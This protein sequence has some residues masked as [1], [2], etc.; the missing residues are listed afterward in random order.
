MALLRSDAPILPLIHA[1]GDPVSEVRTQA[2]AA[3]RE[4]SAPVVLPALLPMLQD[5]DEEVRGAAALAAGDLGAPES[6]LVLLEILRHGSRHHR[7]QAAVCLRNL[8][9]AAVVPALMEALGDP[10]PS[11]QREAAVSL[12]TL[13]DPQAAPVLIDALGATNIMDEER[14][15]L[16]ENLVKALGDLEDPR[17]APALVRALD[18]Y[19]KHVRAAAV[20]SLVKLG[21]PQ[22]EDALIGLV[23]KNIFHIRP[24]ATARVAIR[25]LGRMGAVRAMP[26]LRLV[27]EDGQLELA[28]EAARALRQLGDTITA[29]D[30]MVWLNSSYSEQRLRAVL[31]LPVLVDRDALPHL[32]NALTDRDPKVRAASARQLGRL[33]D[34]SVIPA[35]T[36]ALRDKAEAEDVRAAIRGALDSLAKHPELQSAAAEAE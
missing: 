16:R 26:V 34:E 25:N 7:Q 24:D 8:K 11:V 13:G 36:N 9:D 3:L 1:L 23:D 20:L 22:A 18:D 4:F 5:P 19:D 17:A 27:I 30:M 2:A 32:L 33:G 28:P 10:S 35:L 29:G 31:T 14:R 21:G 6:L 15:G 12:G